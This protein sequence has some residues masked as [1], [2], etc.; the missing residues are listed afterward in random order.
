MNM[1]RTISTTIVTLLIVVGALLLFNRD[2]VQAA[3]TQAG[4]RA[5]TRR[6]RLSSRWNR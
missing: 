3:M 6:C 5:A 2:A 1:I 4:L